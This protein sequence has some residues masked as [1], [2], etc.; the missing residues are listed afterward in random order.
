MASVKR[1]SVYTDPNRVNSRA[2]ELDLSVSEYIRRL[3]D[4]DM[5]MTDVSAYLSPDIQE[6]LER[7]AKDR[8]V[9]PAYLVKEWVIRHVMTETEHVKL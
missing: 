2:A 9:T 8:Q 1:V 3:L 5:L 7:M 6:R 4:M